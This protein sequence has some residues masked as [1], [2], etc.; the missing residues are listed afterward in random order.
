MILRIFKVRNQKAVKNL[1]FLSSVKVLALLSAHLN[2]RWLILIS[3][4]PVWGE[5]IAVVSIQI[6]SRFKRKKWC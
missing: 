3:P 5:K 2:L 6:H 4:R 1:G